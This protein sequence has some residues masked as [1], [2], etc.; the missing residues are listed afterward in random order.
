MFLENTPIKTIRFI[1]E[2]ESIP[3]DEYYRL[4]MVIHGRVSIRLGES[5]FTCKDND[6]LLSEPQIPCHVTPANGAKLLLVQLRPSAIPGRPLRYRCNSV[7]FPDIDAGPLRRLMAQ[8]TA[9]YL[10]DEPYGYLQLTALAYEL[11]YMLIHS[12]TLEP[13][14]DSEKYAARL[15]AIAEYMDCH[16]NQSVTLEGIADYL[17][18]TPPY[19]SRFFKDHF[20]MTFNRYINQLRFTKA[21]DALKNTGAS[22]TDIVHDH[23]F[24]NMSAFTSMFK[25]VYHTTPGKYRRECSQVT[26]ANVSEGKSVPKTPLISDER[27]WLEEYLRSSENDSITPYPSDYIIKNVN[28]A[29]GAQHLSPFWKMF[30]AGK[31]SNMSHPHTSEQLADIRRNMNFTYGAVTQLM[32]DREIPYDSEFGRYDF[33]AFDH[34]VNTL[35][36]NQ[37]TPY[38]EL[39]EASD[40]LKE[41]EQEVDEDK[42]IH[43][44]KALLNH[45]RRLYNPVHVS[46]W[47]FDI[48]FNQS[49][50]VQCHE[51]AEHFILRFKQAA[52][53]I[54]QTFPQARVGGVGFFTA[55]PLSLMENLLDRMNAHKITPDFIS[56]ICYPY[57]LTAK[58]LVYTAD[59]ASL[60]KKITGIQA[61]LRKY[62][63]KDTELIISH[64]SP[65][66][67][68]RFF[69]GDTCYQSAFI[70]HMSI[71]LAGYIHF[72]GYDQISD[73]ATE[74]NA[75]HFAD[76]RS[77]FF[78]DDNL[79]KPGYF[80]LDFLSRTEG[81]I[82]EKSDGLLITRSIGGNYAIL[83]DNY[84]APDSYYCHNLSINIRPK[85]AYSVYEAPAAR[86]LTLTLTLLENGA[87]KQVT[88]RLNREH[89]SIFDVWQKM[90]YWEDAIRSDIEYFRQTTRPSREYCNRQVSGNELRLHLTLAPHEVVLVE[91]SP[92]EVSY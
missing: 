45:C 29:Q 82:V 74:P 88:H 90:N 11:I 66:H 87:W 43:R 67:L 91:L 41:S 47:M 54:R 5:T 28:M 34:A 20:G 53:L 85:H 36:M 52:A 76:A 70:T 39:N 16:Y 49:F 48:G 32:D 27:P 65:D 50:C 26:P 83:L 68:H 46:R 62:H 69:L 17:H 59:A 56:L 7:Q 23:G 25:N 33:L 58:G 78:S 51:S 8:L 77:G 21:V 42:Y 9:V 79:P 24:P 3:S 15:T 73:S 14:K 55:Y 35:H 37:L 4:L 10:K 84:I 40:A 19:L 6:L 60:I 80:A 44:L 22:I 72:A 89:G 64:L 12:Y 92:E 31:P 30:T 61:A 38:L 1:T 81:C 18:L 13:P 2:S 57:E 75:S 63:M 86:R 71:A